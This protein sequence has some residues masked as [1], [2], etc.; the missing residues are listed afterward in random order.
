MVLGYI[1]ARSVKWVYRIK[2]I[3]KSFTRTSP[4]QRISLFQPADGRAQPTTNGRHSDSENA[5]ELRHHV[6]VD[7]FQD[8]YNQYQQRAMYR[9]SGQ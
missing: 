5:R 1:G 2:A 7:A 3:E 6:S 8:R 9:N 4:K